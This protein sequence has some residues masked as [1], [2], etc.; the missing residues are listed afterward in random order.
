M[1]VKFHK[2]FALFQSKRKTKTTN[3]PCQE[4]ARSKP[5]NTHSS[6]DSELYDLLKQ[7]Q[8]G[9]SGIFE[10]LLNRYDRLICAMTNRFGGTVS[11]ADAD[12]LRQEAIL[13]LYRAA[14]RFNLEQKEVQFGLFAKTCI[15]HALLSHL[16]KQKK[17]EALVL[18]E[19]DLLEAQA[20][21]GKCDPESQLIEEES[22]L[23]LSAQIRSALSEHENRI[24]WLYL[25]GRT[26]K[27]IAVCIEKD[28][29]SVQNAIYRIRRKLRTI[30]PT[31]D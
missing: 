2:S 27:E 13:A 7:I 26:A 28:E 29:K 9:D 10:V 22:Y 23:S 12:D 16:R 6:F 8:N 17:L 21:G 4:R 30:I 11:A 3:H 24:W 31:P 20:K 25:S 1:T 5:M 19:D 15:R 18:L 14:M